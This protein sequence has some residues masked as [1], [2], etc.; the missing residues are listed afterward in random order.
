M[1]VFFFFF[2]QRLIHLQ[3]IDCAESID[4]EANVFKC[5]ITPHLIMML[6]IAAGSAS[7]HLS[8]TLPLF[9]QSLHGISFLYSNFILFQSNLFIATKLWCCWVNVSKAGPSISSALRRL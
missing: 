2:Q 4:R 8:D 6:L 9:A 1:P 5:K 3:A 7:C